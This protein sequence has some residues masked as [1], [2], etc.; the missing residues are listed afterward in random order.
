[1]S[2]KETGELKVT[3]PLGGFED[4]KPYA[5][6][7]VDGKRVEVPMEYTHCKENP[8]RGFVYGF[9]VGDYDPKRSL[10]LDPT[11]LI[12]CGYIGGSD[13]DCGWGI[14]VDDGGNAYVTGD[15][16]SDEE[17]FP[18]KVGPDL[19]YNDDEALP[20]VFVAKVNAP[21]TE[22]VYCGYIG[23]KTFDSGWDIAVDTEGNAYVTGWTQSDESSFPVIV[24][25]DLTYNDGRDGFVAKVNASGEDLLYCGYIGGSEVDYGQSIVVDN[26]GNAYITG[27]TGSTESS[28]PVVV[29]PD[30]THNG[31]WDAFVAKVAEDGTSFD[32]CGYIGGTGFEEGWG[33]AVDGG[34]NAYVTGYTDSDETSFPV[35]EGPCLSY[36]GGRDAFV[37]KV[38]ASGIGLSYCGYIG[39]TDTDHGVSIA[40]DELQGYAY[41]SGSTYSTEASFPVKNGPD[42]TA[43][44]NQDAFVAKVTE[45][46]KSLDY[47]GYIGGEN[48]DSGA[49]IDVDIL[50]SAYVTGNASSDESTFPVV[51]G[52]DLTHN[53]GVYDAYVA[54]VNDQGTDLIYCG[55]IGGADEDYTQRIAVDSVGNA[56]V[57]GRTLSDES[58]FPVVVG[59]DLTHNG[60]LDCFVAKVPSYHILLRA[61]N[62]GTKHGNPVD[63][64]FANINN[65]GDSAGSDAYRTFIVPLNTRVKMK[66]NASPFGPNPSSFLLYL[67]TWEA[68]P[69]D[70]CT[71]PYGIGTA[72]FPMPLCKGSVMPPPY[73]VVNN[74]GYRN[75]LGHPLLD[76]PGGFPYAP[77][78][79]FNVPRLPLGAYT[80]QG[81]LFDLGSSGPN[82]SLTN[83]IVLKVQ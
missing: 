28:F 32:Y 20:D 31:T 66:M 12:Y 74:I 10:I 37:A 30:L 62:V 70:V 42:L 46:G 54:K 18:V 36:N 50:G 75:V 76:P 6:Q 81:M 29:G 11:M 73:T 45:D 17:S 55:Y 7:E 58:T 47:C 72:C 2:L 52:P 26:Q 3:T 77:C 40:V 39:G 35:S 53:E 59:P 19:T 49:G 67:I 9:H 15:T 79:V 80:F 24:G 63:V 65:S 4:A 48:E 78:T 16:L 69:A 34:W 71:L 8:D 60:S 5:Y 23:G 43:N 51:V 44:G 27:F 41:I 56:Y 64:L 57:T 22:L 82:F 68:G 33:I 25:P 21:G 13:S 83:A 14:A 38:N 61:G 1:M